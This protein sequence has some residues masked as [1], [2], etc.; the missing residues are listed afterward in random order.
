MRASLLLSVILLGCAVDGSHLSGEDA[1]PNVLLI[2]ADDQGWADAH[3][4]ALERLAAR[5]VR[6]TQAYA[7][8]PICNASRAALL[9]GSYQQRFGTF[10]YGG[11][12]LHDP[13]FVTLAELLK[14]RGYATGYVGKFHYGNHD[15]H[16][17]GRRSFPLEHG[18]D[19]LYG[20]SGGRKHYLSHRAAAEEA[21]QDEKRR[22][23]RKGQSLRQDPFWVDAQLEDQEGFSTELLGARA[24]AFVEA[25]ADRPFFLTVGFNAVHNFTHQLPAEYLDRHGLTGYPRDWSPASEEYY[26][27]YRRGRAPNNPEGR[28]QY[29]GQLHY[30]D[31]EV[32]RLLDELKRQDLERDTLVIYIGDNGGS[33]PIYADNGPLRG[34]KYTLY[35]GGIRVPLIV[36]WPERFERGVVR[37]NVVSAMD[38]LP[39][40]CRAAGAR[41]PPYVDGLDLG[42][43]LRGIDTQAHHDL[44]VWDTNHETAVRQGRWKLRTAKSDSHAKYEMV[45]LELG[46]FLH[47]LSAD[48][49]EATNLA[50][51]H[52]E[53]VDRLLAA[54]ATWR[55][56]LSLR[57]N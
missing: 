51:R 6:F 50:D 49:G 14:E 33:T 7:S 2:I 20:F 8:S 43:L 3:T 37:D 16:Q 10:W 34:S 32:G 19:S 24:R 1:P 46:L 15:E 53:M 35:E 25:N 36:S 27:W 52:P 57:S 38:V 13:A 22:H 12:G 41:T 54:H 45:E 5:G 47:D 39:T 4:P 30:L 21:F 40:V 44:L 11:K 29:R 56:G 31:R 26:D 18:Y 23:A 28:A 42:A 55:E 48:P 17:P 9:T